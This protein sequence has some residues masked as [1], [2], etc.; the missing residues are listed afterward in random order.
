MHGSAWW[1]SVTRVPT[2]IAIGFQQSSGAGRG[3]DLKD[4]V[5]GGGIIPE[6][7]VML[8]PDDMDE[9]LPVEQLNILL[10][11]NGFLSPYGE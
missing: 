1:S 3:I 6:N 4:G 11:H 10:P 8:D 9:Q 7:G 2:G 5:D